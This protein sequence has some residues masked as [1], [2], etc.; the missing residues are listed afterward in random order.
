MP[1]AIF[2]GLKPGSRSSFSLDGAVVNGPRG[3][4]FGPLSAKSG[5]AI[6][7]VCGSRGSGR[8]ALLLALAGR[9]RLGAGSVTV[10]GA[11]RPAEIRRCVGIAGFAG[12]DTLEPTAT[13]AATLRERLAWVS[14]WFR[15]TPKLTPAATHALL[16]DAFGE[17]EQPAADTLVRDLVPSEELLLR[18]SLALIER[19]QLLVIDDFD[20]L[21][22]AADRGLV[23]DR[24]TAL[25][26]SGIRVVL[27]TTD[28]A[29]A[30]HFAGEPPA[31][32]EL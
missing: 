19:P 12:I 23:A 15:R 18:V 22:S 1:P 31:L 9:M 26:A 14:P 17:L 4:V 28:P 32:I 30:L 6:T 3:A 24:L 5:S 11:T 2:E 27:A 20:E 8:T 13:I 21:R 10:L 7:V 16:N 29:D 25:A